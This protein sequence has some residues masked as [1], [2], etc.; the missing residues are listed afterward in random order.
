MSVASKGKCSFLKSITQVSW[1]QGLTVQRKGEGGPESWRPHRGL[2]ENRSADNPGLGL[3][4]QGM[5]SFPKTRF[6]VLSQ[7]ALGTEV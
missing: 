6:F 1:S 3:E 4:T 2:G 5:D 7:G